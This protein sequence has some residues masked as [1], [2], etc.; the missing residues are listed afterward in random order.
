MQQRM[1]V[2]TRFASEGFGGSKFTPMRSI[3]GSL[4]PVHL[5]QDNGGPTPTPAPAPAP[6]PDVVV[7]PTYIL[8]P[9]QPTFVAPPPREI[10]AVGQEESSTEKT[11]ITVAAAIGLVALGAVLF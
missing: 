7:R 4:G 10:V 8:P 5:A 6:A 1:P 3:G 2:N 11:L 9:A